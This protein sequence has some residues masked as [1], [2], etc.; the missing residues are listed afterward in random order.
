MRAGDPRGGDGGARPAG[1]GVRRAARRSGDW[2]QVVQGRA[3][4]AG[5]ANRYF[6][7]D[8]G[9]GR[10]VRPSGAPGG[11]PGSG[12]QAGGGTAA[13]DAAAA[14]G[15]CG[16]GDRGGRG[17][18]GARGTGEGIVIGGV[19]GLGRRVGTGSE[20]TGSARA[21][22]GKALAP[23]RKAAGIAER[24][25]SILIPT[26]RYAGKVGRAV[27]SALASGAGEIVVLDDHSRDGTLQR[28]ARYRDPRLRVIENP[29]TL[30]LWENHRAALGYA[31]RPWI[32]FLQADDYLLPGGLAA[33][34]GAAAAGVTVVW[35]CA[36]VRDDVTGAVMQYHDLAAPRRLT[37]ADVLE[38]SLAGGWLLGSP[39]HMMLRLD[40]LPLEAAAWRTEISA[41]V[42]MGA[43][44]AAAGDVA[45][46]PPGAIG[47]GAHAGQDAR[48]QGHRRGLRRMVATSAYLAARPEPVLRRF[49]A[50]W[51]AMNR[52]AA[53][54]TALGGA[55]RGVIPPGEALRLVLENH[56]LGRPA[57]QARAALAGAR[58]YRRATRAPLDLVA[59][60]DRGPVGALEVQVRGQ[61]QGYGQGLREDAA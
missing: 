45:L 30:G 17:A 40:A 36:L 16:A 58:A 60:L 51:A 54:R 5:A 57:A 20:R 19:S 56:A 25:I 39:S 1:V 15:T 61:E 59:L 32:K 28:L 34:A 42:V 3:G 7:Q 48:T 9:P 18:S 38:A 21:G 41:D 33:Y 31:T 23:E 52:R 53:L 29:R 13:G 44:A 35:G 6:G 12:A 24:D 8:E 2:A 49:A 27:M 11:W 55:R 50:L 46:L 22:A 4:Q 43:V 26:Y 37:G 14:A 47:Q 10:A